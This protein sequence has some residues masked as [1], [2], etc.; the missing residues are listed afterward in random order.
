MKRFFFILIL[1]CSSCGNNDMVEKPEDLIAP[2]KMEK[3]LYE[4]LLIDAIKGHQTGL[5]DR[6]G[7]TPEQFIYQRYDIDSLQFAK[8]NIYYASKTKDFENMYKRIRQRFERQKD[9]L[10]DAISKAKKDKDS[11]LQLSDTK[12]D[13]TAIEK[14]L[15]N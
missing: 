9:S 13:S 7:S 11:I 10:N 2:E 3:I 1:C 14:I 5:I 15:K 6:L 12:T 8:S 4:L